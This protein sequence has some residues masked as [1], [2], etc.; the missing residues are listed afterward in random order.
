LPG[1][2]GLPG[3]DAII[4]DSMLQGQKGE[5]GDLGLPGPKGDPGLRGLPGLLGAVG[6]P[7]VKGPK[8]VLNLMCVIKSKLNTNT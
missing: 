5:P 7:G 2:A 4:S 1:P 3:R 6:F 8:V